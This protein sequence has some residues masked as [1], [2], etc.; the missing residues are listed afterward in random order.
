MTDQLRSYLPI[1]IPLA[2]IEVG[3]MIAALIHIFTHKNYRFGNRWVWVVI[4]VL[5]NIIGPILYFA[6]GRGENQ[7]DEQ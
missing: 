6:V 4:S 3:L 5:F 7:D 2:V 1:I